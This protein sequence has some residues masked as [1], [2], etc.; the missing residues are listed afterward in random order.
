MESNKIKKIITLFVGAFV[1]GISFWL[2]SKVNHKTSSQDSSD[3]INVTQNSNLS[4][5]K[6]SLLQPVAQSLPLN[7][8]RLPAQIQQPSDN[9]FLDE[10]P[11]SPLRNFLK[12]SQI[13]HYEQTEPNLSGQFTRTQLVKTSFIYPLIRMKEY[14]R[15]NPTN[16]NIESERVSLIVADHLVVKLQKGQN[17]EKLDSFLNEL[18]ATIR[19][20]L[21]QSG[22][23]L[24]SFEVDQKNSLESMMEKL[25]KRTDIIAKVGIDPIQL[26]DH[27]GGGQ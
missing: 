5:V 11:S 3:S 7:A 21:I 10:M 8:S 19:R 25:R 26:V 15:K 27:V 6:G 24:V 13:I 17:R 2:F 14:L 4:G 23:Y 1:I 18:S 16:G 22:M 20:E 12:N 9:V